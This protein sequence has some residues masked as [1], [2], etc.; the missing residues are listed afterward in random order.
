MRGPESIIVDLGDLVQQTRRNPQSF[1][2]STP[3]GFVLHDHSYTAQ[4][5]ETSCPI[6]SPT[7]RETSLWILHPIFLPRRKRQ[8]QERPKCQR[9]CQSRY[10]QT[11]FLLLFLF[12]SSFPP[13]PIITAA[14][15]CTDS[16]IKNYQTTCPF[17]CTPLHIINK[18]AI[19][20]KQ[21]MTRM[22]LPLPAL[23]SKRT[24]KR[25]S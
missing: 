24:I 5:T 16:E 7:P 2:L 21:N 17:L 19:T 13:R 20:S 12:L 1:A 11:F 23:H 3:Q 14:L 10:C 25:P 9:Q 18:L 6:P 4:N 22:T 15:L 8:E